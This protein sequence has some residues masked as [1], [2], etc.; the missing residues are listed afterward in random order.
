MT[1]LITILSVIG[2]ILLAVLG[3]I[4][5][6]MLLVLLVPIR[7]RTR[8]IKH[9]G[10]LH[11]AGNVSWLLHL[12]HAPFEG[13]AEGLQKEPGAEDSSQTQKKKLQYE[14]RWDVRVLGISLKKRKSRK[15]AEAGSAAADNASPGPDS[16]PPAGSEAA[17]AGAAP[18]KTVSHEDVQP[19]ADKAG[20]DARRQ[21]AR[22][23]MT[24]GAKRKPSVQPG[25]KKA[26]KAA[27]GP[28][29]TIEIVPAKRPGR[30]E[31][32]L[33]RYGALIGRLKKQLE[34]GR[35]AAEV[36]LAWLDYADSDSFEHGISCILREV[37]A[38]ILHI[39]PGHISGTVEFG[40]EDPSLTGRILAGIAVFYP[41]VPRKL[42]IVPDFE[43]QKLEADAEIRGRI[44]IGVILF[45]ALKLLL[46]RDVR[47][48][49]SRIRAKSPEDPVLR[50]AAEKEKKKLRK[51]AALT[52][53]KKRKNG[54]KKRRRKQKSRKQ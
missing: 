13:R 34:K 9:G 35:S 24:E 2:K 42:A 23:R 44:V 5:V 53:R 6:L 21:E 32:L 22:R 4:I 52:R 19:Q 29:I 50:K 40:M 46:T 47:G 12:I 36:I 54:K 49:I 39:L 16:S 33:A 30:F 37:K 28:E 18:E 3:L 14:M 8:I 43:K 31:M 38:V 48:L 41:A 15:K 25:E 26:E 20:D 27:P 10:S 45:R 51:R 11:A 7:Y 1:I 17:D